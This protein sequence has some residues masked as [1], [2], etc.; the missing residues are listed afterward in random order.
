[1]NYEEL[2]VK[3]RDNHIF[4]DKEVKVGKSSERVVA[5]HLTA[6]SFAKAEV[7]EKRLKELGF[8]YYQPTPEKVIKATLDYAK[9]QMTWFKRDK[10]IHW[11]KTIKEA[12][13]LILK[14][15]PARRSSGK[16]ERT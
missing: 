5:L 4:P 9:R 1:M 14:L 13:K 16:G 6:F 3:L 7:I 11:V 12:E 15:L 8:E 2:Y 10:D